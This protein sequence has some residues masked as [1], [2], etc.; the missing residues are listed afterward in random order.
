MVVENY[1]WIPGCGP[2]ARSLNHM[3]E[4][5]KKPNY[6]MG[7]A[8]SMSRE[9]LLYSEMME[10]DPLTLSSSYLGEVLGEIES[11]T[12]CFGHFGEWDD[13]FQFLLPV[14]IE[15]SHESFVLEDTLATF[16]I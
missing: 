12:R 13:W 15:R 10:Q 3:R 4:R 5:I 16:F 2:S 11:G 1:Q 9:P 8:W 6:P 7:E 14:L